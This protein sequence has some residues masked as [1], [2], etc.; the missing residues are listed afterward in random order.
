M[1]DDGGVPARPSLVIAAAVVLFVVGA[2]NL[3]VGLF[4][5]GARLGGAEIVLNLLS[6]V[7]GAASIWAASQILQLREQGRALGVGIAA[8]GAIL[9]LLAIVLGNLYQ[10]LALL[11]Y[12]FVLYALVTQ[13]PAFRR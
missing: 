4:L 6:V 5:F 12:G 8:V 7:L 13:A 1:N 11:L 9:A 3:I 2:L 10:L